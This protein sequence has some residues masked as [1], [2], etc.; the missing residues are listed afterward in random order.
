MTD[1]AQL[2]TPEIRKQFCERLN[3]MTYSEAGREEREVAKVL[4]WEG[5]GVWQQ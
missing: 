5:Y 3:P 4:R 1:Y 2:S